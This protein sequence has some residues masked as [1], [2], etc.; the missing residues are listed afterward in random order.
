MIERLRVL[1]SWG[2]E[3]Q[4]HIGVPA[5]SRT[6]SE[7]FLREMGTE[8]D[9]AGGYQVGGLECHVSFSDT[10]HPHDISAQSAME[11]HYLKILQREKPDLVWAHYTDF[12][13]VTSSVRWNPDRTWV[14]LTDN[15]FPRQLELNQFPTVASAYLNLRTVIVASRFMQRSLRTVMPWAQILRIPNPVESLQEVNPVPR[16]PRYWIFVNPIKVKGVE[17]MLNLVTELPKE[18][19]LFVGNWGNDRPENLP[20]NVEWLPR[21]NGLNEVFQKAKG[22]L[23][24]SVWDEAFGR[25]VL[26][27]MA[28]GVPVISSDRGS[29]PETVGDGGTVLPLEINQWRERL[30]ANNE[31]YWQESVMRGIRRV[32]E[33]RLE[34]AHRL[35]GLHRLLKRH[36]SLQG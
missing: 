4:I 15:E 18:K 26:E 32:V 5:S 28:A 20:L 11:D 35:K 31:P 30:Q 2:A 10:F 23:M 25:L 17:F 7:S 3:I 6:A 22:L 9:S 16:D 8:L 29:L 24:P 21:Q 19:F 33:Y 34:T 13:S 12:F 14:V 36:F 1:K 27:S